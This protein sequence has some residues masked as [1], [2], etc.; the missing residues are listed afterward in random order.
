M[1]RFSYVSDIG[2][3]RNSFC[4]DCLYHLSNTHNSLG[5][6]RETDVC[7]YIEYKNSLFTLLD[8]FFSRICQITSHDSYLLNEFNFAVD[9]PMNCCPRP[10]ASGNSSSGHPQHLGGDSFDCCTERYEI[11][12]YC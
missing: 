3:C 10:S 12:V 2:T 9:G 11:V 6:E 5:I 7:F 8:N 4:L 1:C